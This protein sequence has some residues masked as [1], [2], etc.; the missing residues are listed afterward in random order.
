M[1]GILSK[2]DRVTASSNGQL[3]AIHELIG[4]GGQGEVYRVDYG[5]HPHALKWYY[6]ETATPAQR[7]CIEKLVEQGPPS[8]S[9]LWPS[10]VAT[11]AGKQSF[12]YVMSLRQD[13]FKSFKAIE[14]S[15]SSM[16]RRRSLWNADS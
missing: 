9:F 12:G 11:I 15:V 10:D 2:H 3:I 14:D 4:S 7:R 6:E 5:G 1:N 8:S 13:R 16:R